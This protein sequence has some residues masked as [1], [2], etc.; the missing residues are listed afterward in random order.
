MGKIT[1]NAK[2]QVENLETKVTMDD[3]ATI[4]ELIRKAAPEFNFNPGSSVIMFRGEEI[5]PDKTLKEADIQD[6]FAVLI[7]P[8]G[9]QKN[10][11]VTIRN[12][13]GGDQASVRI[14]PD[15]T[16]RHVLEEAASELNLD[17][18]TRIIP[19]Y[20][21]NPLSLDE[22]FERAGIKDDSI[23]ILTPQMEELPETPPQVSQTVTPSQEV[24][25]TQGS[26]TITQADEKLLREMLGEYKARNDSLEEKIQGNFLIPKRVA[27]VLIVVV[28]ISAILLLSWPYL[29][30]IMT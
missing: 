22:T 25:P 24:P 7:L 9:L 14:E 30:T 18:M 4:R 17:D 3:E 16:V 6:G 12:V 1:I 11:T 27:Y 5:P 28:V 19:M 26:G 20:N 23:I 21:G 2:T 13:L 15:S 10:I 8:L 29:S